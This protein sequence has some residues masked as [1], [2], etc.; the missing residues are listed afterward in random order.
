MSQ[1]IDQA[2]VV[3]TLDT[4]RIQGELATGVDAPM[5]SVGRIAQATTDSIDAAFRQLISELRFEFAVLADSIDSSLLE[6]RTAAEV[7]AGEI[8][9]EFRSAAISLERNISVATDAAGHDLDKLATKSETAGKHLGGIGGLVGGAAVA[10][11]F[12]ALTAGLGTLTAFGLKSA[13]SLEQVQVAFNSL[14]GSVAAGTAQFKALQQFANATPFTFNDLTTAAQ[15]FDAFSGSVG[16]AQNQLIPFLTTIGNLVSETG[17]GAQSL[18]S[19]S[20]ALGQTASQGKLTLGNLEQ[21]N[22]A[23]PGFNSVAAIAAVRGETTAQVMNE[24]AAGTISASQGIPQLLKGMQQFPGAAGAMDRQAQ[25]L[26]GVF[27]TFHDVISQSLSNAFAPVIPAIKTSLL[28][29]TPILGTALD[30]LAPAIGGF[31]AALLPTLGQVATALT[32]VLTPL[33]SQLGPA[34]VTLTPSIAP[35]GAALA[36]IAIALAPLIPML[37][38]TLVAA[39][40]IITP[41]LVALAPIITA[42]VGPLGSFL[43]LL[44]SHLDVVKTIAGLFLEFTA[45]IKLYN[46]YTS[47]AKTAT[48]LWKDAQ[49]ALD[50]VMDANPIGLIVIAIAALIAII[51]VIATKTHFFQDAWRDTWNFLKGVG[52]WFAGPF[53]DFFVNLYHDVVGFFVELPGKIRD[54]LFALPHLLASAASTA[55]HAFFFAIGFG[56]GLIIKE[57]LAFPG[58]V[59]AILKG[60]WDFIVTLFKTQ[61]ALIVF[62]VKT[63]PGLVIGFFKKLWDGAVSLT[64]KGINAVIKFFTS[65]PGKAMTQVNNLKNSILNFFKSAP[66]WLY[67]AGKDVVHGL[68]NGITSM[69]TSAIKAVTGA[70]GSIIDGAKSALGIHS[71]STV[72]MEIGQQTVAGYSKGVD[73][74]SYQARASVLNAVAPPAGVV[75]AASGSAGAHGGQAPLFGPGSIVVTFAGVVPT[76]AEA[77][78]TGQA[79][80]Q[81]INDAL[82]KRNARNAVRTM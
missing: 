28:Q 77:M 8:T 9:S 43:G 44:T 21:I 63:L 4:S 30:K 81:G 47:I 56:I 25:T 39:L 33:I 49:A 62:E 6:T 20:L 13:A 57:F 7:A 16:L 35:L 22:N 66:S 59:W 70:I 65:L 31:L 64:T 53:K 40:Q 37:A 5:E 67:N 55:F 69:V 68:I 24:L 14:T 75:A 76:Q 19:I 32:G 38:T 36:Q 51:V 12:T 50:V 42:I 78:A 29:I 48:D 11:G 60:M 26:L 73:T 45:A 1:P 2:S 41:L 34:L 71:P 79:V 82:T 15:R 10:G 54:A 18:D 23:I 72:F 74:T 46:I 17:G 27:S 61:V 80:G 52:A 3:L 58:Q